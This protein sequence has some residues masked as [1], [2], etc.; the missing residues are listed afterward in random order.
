M[1]YVTR[2]TKRAL[3][4]NDKVPQFCTTETLIIINLHYGFIQIKIF[5]F[6]GHCTSGK[7]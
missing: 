2:R 4:K 5:Y 6:H 3:N 7:L 1:S